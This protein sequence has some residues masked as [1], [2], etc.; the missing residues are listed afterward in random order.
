MN[1]NPKYR[2][3]KKNNVFLLLATLML[4]GAGVQ[5]QGTDCSTPIVVTSSSPFFE[6]FE[7]ASIPACWTQSV[8]GTWSVRSSFSFTGVGPWSGVFAAYNADHSSDL[9]TPWFDI[10]AMTDCRLVFMQLRPSYY[11]YA[12]TLEVLVRTSDSGL[13]QTLATYA[14]DCS[15]WT[16]CTLTLPAGAA[17]CQVAFRH[18]YNG[19][20]CCVLDDIYIGE[21]VTCKRVFDLAAVADSTDSVTLSWRDTANIGATYTVGWGGDLGPT[22]WAT[23]TDTML[24][25]GG[26]GGGTLYH[27]SV[28]ASCTDGSQSL[29]AECRLRTAPGTLHIPYSE[30]FDDLRQYPPSGWT[31]LCGSWGVGNWVNYGRLLQCFNGN[32]NMIALPPTDQPTGSLQVRLRTGMYGDAPSQLYHGTMSVGY[33]TDTH[34]IS[35]YVS[36]ASWPNTECYYNEEKVALMLGAPDSALIVLRWE[37]RGSYTWFVDDVVVE[38]IPA[39]PRPIAVRATGSTASSIDLAISGLIENYRIYWTDGTAT[40]SLD[41]SDSVCTITGLN[42]NTEYTISVVTNCSDGSLTPPV[43]VHTRTMCNAVAVPYVDDFESYP[44]E[45]VPYCWTALE[46]NAYVGDYSMFGRSSKTLMFTGGTGASIA[47]PQFDMPVDTLQVRFWLKPLA[48]AN[49][50]SGTFSVGWQ[51]D[52]SDSSTF[53]EMDSW[54]SFDWTSLG[55]LEKAV[56]MY[57]APADARIV[58]RQHLNAP[59]YWWAVDSV[60]VEPMPSCPP[61]TRLA[62]TGVGYDTVAV[63]FSGGRTGNYRLCITDGVAYHDTVFV[64]DTH[65]YTFTGLDTITQYTICVASDC[66]GEVSDSLV[67]RA[68]T[69]MPAD[70]LPYYTG[71]EPGDDVAWRLLFSNNDNEWCIGSAVSNG[72]SRS[73][74]ITDDFGASNH[75]SPG[76]Q[77]NPYFSNSYAYKTFWV[78]APAEYLISYDWHSRGDLRVFLAPASFEVNT[79]YR[80]YNLGAPEGWYALDRGNYMNESA[81]WQNYEQIF[82]VDTPGYYHLIFYWF[83]GST[84]GAQPPAAIDNVRFERV[85]CPAVRNVVVDSVTLTAASISWTPFGT[86]SEWEVTVGDRTDYVS[87]PTYYATGLAAT[88]TYD[89]VVRPVCG[90]GDTG[91]PATAWFTTA[92]CERATVMKNYDSTYSRI[93]RN[94]TPFGTLFSQRAYAQIIIPAEFLNSSGSEITALAYEVDSTNR[95]IVLTNRIDVYMANVRENVLDAGFIHPDVDHRFVHVISN[96]DFSFSENRVYTHSFDTNFVWDGQ[97]NVLVAMLRNTPTETADNWAAH[98]TA[99]T[100]N[101]NYKRTRD[102]YSNGAPIDINTVTDGWPSFWVGDIYLISCPSGCDEPVVNDLVTD[103]ESITIYF[104]AQDTVEVVIT[105]G[106]W[107]DTLSGMLLLPS[108]HSYTF[109]G[110]TPM[111]HYNVGIR[112]VCDDSTTSGWVVSSVTTIDVSCLPPTGFA[113]GAT[114]MD[115]QEFSWTPSGVEAMWQIHIFNGFTNALYTVMGSPAT[116]SGL[117]YGTTYHAS[118]RSLCG[119]SGNWP[120]PW[121]D[122]LTFTTVDCPAVPG[123]TVG[124]ITASSATVS[125][126]PVDGSVG[127]RIYYGREWF[128]VSEA[129]VVDVDANTTSYEM[130]GLEGATSYDVFVLNRCSDAILSGVTDGQRVTFT[131]AVGIDAVEEA[132]LMLYPNPASGSVTLS[133]GGFEGQ[134]CVQVVDMNGRTLATTYTSD[135]QTALDVSSFQPGAYFLRVTGSSQTAVRKLIIARL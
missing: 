101:N 4:F 67:V 23:T 17:L 64:V 42:A 61:P 119:S 111:T 29:P 66:G 134:V 129:T 69:E 99:H 20:Y 5:A 72:G 115:A 109:A 108:L 16:E 75:Y 13:W 120:G 41:V 113:L 58:M 54:T 56:P 81:A 130:T 11:G 70:T 122:T 105:S 106:S 34:D 73:L 14:L 36:V 117:Y 30:R 131:T 96:G 51:T 90:V 25:I 116:V 32:S 62:V 50:L 6:D 80:F 10:S 22:A 2:Y 88:T 24:R 12:D 39:C 85:G 107:S 15:A 49:A 91:L 19:A 71:F 43:I 128:Y 60:T 82:T 112:H 48:F 38:V 95:A 133:L 55:A 47:M 118:I 104:D 7:G 89:V 33:V 3:M 77:P 127:Y 93:I 44:Y 98:F 27:F 65:N 68:T 87:A 8:G 110:L 59:N 132:A 63:S 121:G 1:D 31:T 84:P 79:G 114:A 94:D 86:E 97:S 45:E 100:V 37:A 35:T 21:P 18:I 40:D 57:G 76:V 46:G 124:D 126:Q 53:V 74:Y 78:D 26:L 123:V 92:L 9:L 102:T 83:S 52:L 103:A 135:S 125:W 28:V